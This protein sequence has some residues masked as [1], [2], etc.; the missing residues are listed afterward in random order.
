MEEHPAQEQELPEAVL[1]RRERKEEIE[2]VLDCLNPVNK[3]LILLKYEM[4]L[5]YK[6]ISALLGI[7]EGTVK[8]YALPGQTAISTIIWR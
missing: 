6:E 3:Q 1:L 8:S 5:S 4:E 2:G 7:S